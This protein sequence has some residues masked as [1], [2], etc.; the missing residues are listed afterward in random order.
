MALGVLL[1]NFNVSSRLYFLYVD[2]QQFRLSQGETVLVSDGYAALLPKRTS[3][4]NVLL[5]IV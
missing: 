1:R 2:T 3:M 5:R 4:P